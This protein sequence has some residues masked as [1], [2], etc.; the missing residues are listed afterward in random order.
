MTDFI[1]SI[2]FSILDFIRAH[3]SCAFLDAV[4]PVISNLNNRGE[5]WILFGLALL[6]AKKYKKYG[7]YILVG[8]L[9]GLFL[10]NGVLKNLIARPRPFSIR[11]EI[12][13]IIPPP[14][15]YSFPSGHTL[16]SFI[17]A[18]LLIRADKRLG[19]FGIILASLIAFSRMYLYVHF[20]T[21]ILGA[22]LLAWIISFVVFKVGERCINLRKQGEKNCEKN[23]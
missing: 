19:I 17:A 10:G 21:D 23:S 16:S 18:F 22:I 2:D 8:L 14:G 11:P 7:A 6:F 20:L 12:S 13:L 9:V 5:I 3:F 1:L 4:M 15:A